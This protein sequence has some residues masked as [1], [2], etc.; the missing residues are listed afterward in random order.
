M[1]L[2]NLT[3]AEAHVQRLEER[4]HQWPDPATVRFLE[5]FH[6][7]GLDSFFAQENQS[8]HVQKWE[9]RTL[10]QNLLQRIEQSAGLDIL[11]RAYNDE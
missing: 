10:S 1:K 11:E 8:G 3:S 9:I 4:R 2:K 7:A 5:P 6:D